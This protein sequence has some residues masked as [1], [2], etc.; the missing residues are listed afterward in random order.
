MSNSPAIRPFTGANFFAEVRTYAAANLFIDL[1]RRLR[2]SRAWVGAQFWAVSSFILVGIAW[3]AMPE[4]PA[5][6]SYL[7][8]LIPLFL[9]A[10]LLV[11]QALT[12]RSLLAEEPGR[13]RLERG[14]LTL[15][16]WAAAAGIAWLLLAWCESRIPL[17]TAYIGSHAPAGEQATLLAPNRLQNTFFL[18]QWALRWI[19]V[20]G[21][22]VPCA[23]AGAQWGPRLPWRRV[24]RLLFDWRWW[25]AVAVAALL[26]VALPGLFISIAPHGSIMHQVADAIFK[27]VASL[28]FA[29]GAWILLLGWT[30]VLLSRSREPLRPAVEAPHTLDWRQKAA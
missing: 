4:T 19:L 10:A 16:A 21:I 24:H 30:A 9:A 15:L 26:G 23:M 11:L 20:P 22:V 27:L 8:W 14:A 13:V 7:S 3:A 2:D 25:P 6:E 5:W 12:M 1:F 17:W 29:L 28:T 18:A